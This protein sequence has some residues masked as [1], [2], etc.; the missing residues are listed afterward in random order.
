M[1]KRPWSYKEGIAI[2]AGLTVIGLLLQITIGAIQWGLF[3]YP[4]NV[5]VLAFFLIALLLMHVSRKRVYLF[6]WLSRTSA[7]VSA[8]AWVVIAT[9]VMGLVK[10]I[11]S[12]HAP[13]DV[14]GISQMLSSWAFVLLY[15]WLITCLGLT[16]IRLGLPRNFS[17]LAVFLSHVGLFVAVVSATLGS[18]DMRRMTM[19]TKI[20]AAEWR[21]ENERGE[22]EELPVAIELEDFSISEYPPKLMLIDNAT[23]HVLPE[24]SP[25]HILLEDGVT[26]GDLMDW[27]IS[28]V[29]TIPM[30]AA[31][32]T[33]D[34]VKYTEFHSMGATFAAYLKAVNKQNNAKREGWVSCGSFVFPYKALRLDSLTSVVMPE[35]E[36]QKYASAVTVYAKSGDVKSDT[37]EVNKPLRIAGWDIYQLS[38]DETKGR[39]SDVSVF[40]LVRDP[41]LPAVYVGITLLVVG[42]IGL[43]LSAERKRKEVES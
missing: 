19:T 37:V 1:W 22:L 15:L 43:F 40:E 27:H 7:A 11:P 21:A 36:P 35:R 32:N 2:G 4:V 13:V 29:K 16:I 26:A 9:V 6:D 38:Y 12:H 31:V 14:L 33:S 30:A 20:G 18:A 28:I 41:W 42:A 5:V 34:T 24:K 10:Q 23:G 8:L 3:A 17:Q 39:W 25:V